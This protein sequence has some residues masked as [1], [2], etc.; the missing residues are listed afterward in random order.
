MH[1]SHFV[2]IPGYIKNWGFDKGAWELNKSNP[3]TW[4]EHSKA[5][6]AFGGW[7]ENPRRNEREFERLDDLFGLIVLNFNLAMWSG[8]KSRKQPLCVLYI[9]TFPRPCLFWKLMHC[10][11]YFIS[12]C[13]KVDILPSYEWSKII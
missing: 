12:L 10:I 13:N 1:T 8:F 7:G 4:G 3:K 6:K 9:L 5:S 11:W 2:C